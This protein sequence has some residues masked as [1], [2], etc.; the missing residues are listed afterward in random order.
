MICNQ[1]L[2]R[3]L[4]ALTL[5]ALS[6]LAAAAQTPTRA[7]THTCC[8]ARNAFNLFYE[9]HSAGQTLALLLEGAKAARTK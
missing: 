8:A 1:S 5:L 2:T 7:V 6:I 3:S 9:M 4:I